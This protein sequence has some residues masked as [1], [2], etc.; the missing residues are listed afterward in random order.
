M[1]PRKVEYWVCSDM[2][3]FPTQ[4]EAEAHEEFL[5]RERFRPT[6]YTDSKRYYGMDDVILGG[7]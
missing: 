7:Q 4:K 6:T 5:A 1:Y 2:R 3:T